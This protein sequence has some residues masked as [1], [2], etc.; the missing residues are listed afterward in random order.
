MNWAFLALITAQAFLLGSCVSLLRQNRRMITLMGDLAVNGQ[1]ADR[2]IYALVNRV[3]PRG[4][5]D[6]SIEEI[7]AAH[8]PEVYRHDDGTIRILAK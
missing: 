6:L 4:H 1:I 7:E 2:V 5:V 8:R 3:S